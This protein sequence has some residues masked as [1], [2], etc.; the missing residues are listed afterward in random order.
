[1]DYKGYILSE[2]KEQKIPTSELQKH[3]IN[4]DSLYS[5]EELQPKELKAILKVIGISQA[6][7]DQK[8]NHLDNLIVQFT[9][10]LIYIN[11]EKAEFVYYEVS[12]YNDFLPYT[13]YNNIAELLK[14]RY[15]IAIRKTEM[16]VPSLK[17]LKKLQ[18][19]FSS[20]ELFLFDFFQG[21]I[22]ILQEDYEEANNRF[23]MLARNVTSLMGFESEFFYH[24]SLIK[25][26]LEESS[27]AIYYG[28]KALE[29]S[30]AQFNFKRS[31]LI[32][33]ALAVNFS[34]ASIY[35]DA[36]E[37][38]DHV[39]RNSEL[40]NQNDLIPH[41]YH[42]MADLYYKM[43]NYSLALAYFKIAQQHFDFDDFNYINCLFNIG[44]TELRLNKK[45]EAYLSF[46]NLFHVAEER[47][48]I[49]F[50]LYA[51][52]YLKYL[53]ESDDD[54]IAFLENEVIP[55]TR[56]HSNEK[57]M[58]VLFSD[59]LVNHYKAQGDYKKAFEYIVDD[60]F[61]N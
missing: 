18:K 55:Y 32:Q 37:C 46:E 60:R 24:L 35:E 52:Y 36:A 2:I 5:N 57:A 1:M 50:S 6:M 53:N 7:I 13:H 9:K 17:N 19:D 11:K 49:N 42:N 54:A 45:D 30:T 21:M 14:L 16:F 56:K 8:L 48:I 12:T 47:K 29:H 28:K 31:V 26:H 33:M 58:N 40:L 4:I 43:E 22:E 25:S 23:E 20:L 38:Y 59:L 34:N 27:R 41:I 3:K 15:Y 61:M 51:S 39:L 44:L 10:H